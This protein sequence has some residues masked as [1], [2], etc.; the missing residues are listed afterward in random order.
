M[1]ARI[2]ALEIEAGN[3]GDRRMVAFCRAALAGNPIALRVVR[4]A[5]V[6]V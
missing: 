2:E 4:K 5:L 3:A 1:T 6:S